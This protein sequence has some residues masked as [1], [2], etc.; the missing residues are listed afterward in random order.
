[1]QSFP[2]LASRLQCNAV[3]GI[4]FQVNMR[5]IWLSSP[6]TTGLLF[7][8]SFHSKQLSSNDPL[9]RHPQ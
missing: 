2:Y 1:M 6:F 8:L 3:S 5:S 4:Y 7:L 9:L